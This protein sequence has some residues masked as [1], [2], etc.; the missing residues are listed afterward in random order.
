MSGTDS[1]K[2]VGEHSSHK[3]GWEAN[4][5]LSVSRSLLPPVLFGEPGAYVRLA[6]FKHFMEW[7]RGWEARLNSALQR[8]FCHNACYRSKRTNEIKELGWFTQQVL[9]GGALSCRWNRPQAPFHCSSVFVLSVPRWLPL[10]AP[11]FTRYR[12]GSSRGFPFAQHTFP[13]RDLTPG[14]LPT[15]PETEIWVIVTIR[16]LYG[17]PSL[18]VLEPLAWQGRWD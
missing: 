2:V 7:K 10:R 8:F 4:R 17:H 12:G 1:K 5:S 9:L 11:S 15:R 6:C 3:K 18:P 14:P 13:S 16:P